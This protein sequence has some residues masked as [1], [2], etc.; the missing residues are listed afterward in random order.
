MVYRAIGNRCI[1]SGDSYA[2]LATRTSVCTALVAANETLPVYYR[3]TRP[4]S[5][6]GNNHRVHLSDPSVA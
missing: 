5:L 2:M 4:L 6:R 1:T 3:N